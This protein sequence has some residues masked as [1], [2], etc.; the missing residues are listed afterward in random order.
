MFKN[1]H[2]ARAFIAF[3]VTWSF[4]VLT[5]T[6]VVL[7]IIPPG[8]VAN[9]IFWRLAGLDREGWI[10]LHILFGAVFIISGAIHLYF[11][12]RPF[13][14][15]LVERV[16]GHLALKRESLASL[17]LVCALVLAALYSVPPI[18]WLFTLN[19]WAKASWD[20]GPPYP[21]AEASPLPVLAERLGFR[22]EEALAAWR[23]AG[24]EIEDSN[25]NLESIARSQGTTPATL[26]ALI[27]SSRPSLPE[28]SAL[29]ARFAGSGLGAQTLRAFAEQQGLEPEEARARLAASEIEANLDETL[30]SIAERAAIRPLEL[31]KIILI[32]GDLPQSPN[33]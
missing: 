18:S 27:P 25:T 26:F 32:P 30:K 20:S 12:W 13:V 14:R 21:R 16:R 2:P 31:A 33:H 23:A 22:L 15:Y 11:N 28:P 5:L 24:I 29:E 19:D 6:G 4:I 3:L 9:W 17:A 1:A 10:H 8:R 7:Y